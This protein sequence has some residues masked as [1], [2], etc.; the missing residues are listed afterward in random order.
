MTYLSLVVLLPLAAVFVRSTEGGWRTFLSAV[1]APDSVAG[2]PV[3]S[4]GAYTAPAAAAAL[5][6]TL[7]AAGAVCGVTAVFGTI[8]A[9][10]LVR[11]E[12]PGKSMINSIIALPFALPTI[13]AGLVLLT[14]Y[15]P[16]SPLG[17]NA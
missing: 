15:G 4:G 5:R 3:P 16:Q 2:P 8:I 7:G 13:V 6:V 12:F 17:L 10:V 1:L 9:G 11:D 14:L